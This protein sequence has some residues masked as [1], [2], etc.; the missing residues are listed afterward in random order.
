MAVQEPF[1]AVSMEPMTAEPLMEGATT[2][3][4]GTASMAEDFAEED[5][6]EPAASEAV[7]W[8]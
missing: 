4:G 7:T 1:A 3:E 2:S 6:V 8:A 5:A